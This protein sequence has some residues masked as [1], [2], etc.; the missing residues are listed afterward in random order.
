MPTTAET[1]QLGITED[2]Y[3]QPKDFILEKDITRINK[4]CPVQ[5]AI[6][7]K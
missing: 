7:Q 3:P 4:E 2:K 6:C 5:F 1:F